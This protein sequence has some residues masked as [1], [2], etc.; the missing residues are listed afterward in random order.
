MT[1]LT[2]T[3]LTLSLLTPSETFVASGDWQS[4]RTAIT[5]ATNSPGADIVELQSDVEAD[6]YTYITEPVTFRGNGHKITLRSNFDGD[7]LFIIQHD[8]GETALTSFQDVEFVGSISGSTSFFRVQEGSGFLLN[9]SRVASGRGALGTGLDCR[10]GCI[11]LD[12]HFRS[13]VATDVGGAIFASCGAAL[14]LENVVIEN[15]SARLGGGLFMDY[16]ACVS[17][18]RTSITTARASDAG[19]AIGTAVVNGP[20]N[21]SVPL[22]LNPNKHW[23]GV[24]CPD[25]GKTSIVN[26]TFSENQ[27]QSGMHMSLQDHEVEIIHSTFGP[28]RPVGSAPSAIHANVG[29]KIEMYGSVFDGRS[30]VPSSSQACDIHSGASIEH[31]ASSL[32]LHSGQSC[33]NATATCTVNSLLPA[34]N[35]LQPLTPVSAGRPWG[36]VPIHALDPSVSS[37]GADYVPWSQWL[38]AGL[39]PSSPGIDQLGNSRSL[40][41]DCGAIEAP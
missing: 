35:P 20:P 36:L 24:I 7:H 13:L 34:S 22:A 29:T 12:T 31:C 1:L 11:V 15:V 17:I 23:G 21:C 14:R 3:F 6:S 5:Q 32:Y 8:E 39:P 40:P 27:A 9:R 37:S 2:H 28:T 19:G 30:G 33:G 4:V 25:F 41:A 26:S 16:R 18:Q 10:G 38:T